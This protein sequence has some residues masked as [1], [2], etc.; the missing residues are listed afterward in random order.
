MAFDIRVTWGLPWFWFCWVH[1]IILHSSDQEIQSQDSFF[2]QDSFDFEVWREH[3][4]LG[5]QVT[6]IREPFHYLYH[7]KSQFIQKDFFP[8]QVIQVTLK[9]S[10]LSKPIT[11]DCTFDLQLTLVNY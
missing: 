6:Y 7:L 8:L 4:L 10:K 2:N 5:I 9:K 1:G 3:I 11:Q